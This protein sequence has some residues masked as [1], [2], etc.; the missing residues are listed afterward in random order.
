MEGNREGC[1]KL[2]M[3]AD[4]L[5]HCTATYWCAHA[6]FQNKNSEWGGICLG[7]TTEKLEHMLCTTWPKVSRLTLLQGHSAGF[8]STF[9]IKIHWS[10]SVTDLILKCLQEDFQTILVTLSTYTVTFVNNLNVYL[11]NMGQVQTEM[12]IILSF[13]FVL[14]A[15]MTSCSWMN[16]WNLR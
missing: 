11:F 5:N 16:E 9:Y 3:L 2:K 4:D 10:L 8:Y 7:D 14:D 13:L 15:V 12:K 1:I 6:T